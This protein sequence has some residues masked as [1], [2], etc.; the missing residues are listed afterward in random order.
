MPSWR[1][2]LAVDDAAPYVHARAA[3]T[4]AA[5]ATLIDAAVNT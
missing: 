2:Q 1:Q 3:G 5:A 4:G